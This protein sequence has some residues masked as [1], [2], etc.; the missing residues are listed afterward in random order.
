MPF[1]QLHI[2]NKYPKTLALTPLDLKQSLKIIKLIKTISV[3]MVVKAQSVDCSISLMMD[4]G[5][6]IG[7]N[8]CSFHY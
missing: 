4:G 5:S 1:Q 8:I 6:N 7:A 3:L 2:L